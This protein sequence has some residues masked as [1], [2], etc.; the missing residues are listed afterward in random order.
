MDFLDSL[1]GTELGAPAKMIIAFMIVL[2]LIAIVFWIARKI[3]GA[4]GQRG[5]KARGPRIGLIE[6]AMVDQ[7]RRLLLVRRDNT[8]HL[9]LIGGTND[10]VI[11][12]GI[13][14]EGAP[15]A[16]SRQERAE[17]RMERSG[18]AASPAAGI[19]QSAAP[20]RPAPVLQKAPAPEP[21]RPV[22]PPLSPARSTP[23]HPAAP[24]TAAAGGTGLAAA[25]LLGA[26]APEPAAVS[27]QPEAR[28]VE[29]RATE[30]RLAEAP[31]GERRPAEPLAAGPRLPEEKPAEA[32]PAIAEEMPVAEAPRVPPAT[33][34]PATPEPDSSAGD[35]MA[36]ATGAAPVQPAG[37]GVSGQR[38]AADISVARPG[39]TTS[40][41]DMEE[42][43]ALLEDAFKGPSELRV[44]PATG[45]ASDDS[46]TSADE[47]ALLDALTGRN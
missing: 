9:I 25:S 39:P 44:E 26:A 15:A 16:S 7:K 45:S 41:Q 21:V 12:S 38:P 10:L 14:R 24:L 20:S 31:A 5:M 43:A 28:P 34:S 13:D 36:A 18:G 11:E 32:K 46:R 29:P 2:L 17:P 40:E 35:G 47:R 3:S 37:T 1:F 6:S 22:P 23:A 27:R 30:P 33:P 8:E 19:A 4:P 42:M